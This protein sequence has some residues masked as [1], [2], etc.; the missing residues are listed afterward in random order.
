[1]WILLMSAAPMQKNDGLIEKIMHHVILLQFIVGLMLEQLNSWTKDLSN[2]LFYSCKCW[3]GQ[4]FTL[5][6]QDFERISE[7]TKI[8]GFV[9]VDFLARLFIFRHVSVEN[10]SGNAGRR[11]KLHC[12]HQQLLDDQKVKLGQ[13]LSVEGIE[14]AGVEFDEM[15][16]F[17][18]N[19]QAK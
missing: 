16:V 9:N 10:R 19:A 2:E 1:M 17:F 4:L 8:V 18:E 3:K 5:L 6:S 12:W 14:P 13:C 7:Y 15:R 11:N